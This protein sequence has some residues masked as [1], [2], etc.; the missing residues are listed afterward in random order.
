HKAVGWMLREVG[1]RDLTIEE[2]FL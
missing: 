2:E 1:K